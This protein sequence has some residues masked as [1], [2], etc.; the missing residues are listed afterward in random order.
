MGEEGEAVDPLE[1]LGGTALR[2]YLHLLLAG[3]PLGVR[4]VQRRLG[5]ASPSTARHH[6]ERL[7][8][9]GLAVKTRDGYRAKPPTR[10]PLA[11]YVAVRGRLLPLSTAALAA[12]LAA[13]GAYLLL[14][15][16]PDPPALAALTAS[17]LAQLAAT[18]HARRL[19]RQLEESILAAG[20]RAG[21]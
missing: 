2:V 4:E 11:L 12:T 15:G 17:T 3:R 9:L 20:R 13:T 21:P 6:L 16:D 19:A 14:P 5:F 18:L 7:V 10:G 8:Q 1:K